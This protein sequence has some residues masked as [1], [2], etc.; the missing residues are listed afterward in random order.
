M[1][2]VETHLRLALDADLPGVR[3]DLL[4]R[5]AVKLLPRFPDI[6][7]MDPVVSRRYPVE[8]R[9]VGRRGFGDK[10]IFFITWSY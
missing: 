4:L 3:P 6:D 7:D 2:I 8:D 10:P 9:S 5:E 1:D